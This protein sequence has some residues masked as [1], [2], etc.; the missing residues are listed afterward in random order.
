MPLDSAPECV[1]IIVTKWMDGMDVYR[2]GINENVAIKHISTCNYEDLQ[3]EPTR[4]LEYIQA[5]VPLLREDSSSPYFTLMATKPPVDNT[6][7]V[8]WEDVPVLLH[9]RDLIQHYVQVYDED[10]SFSIDSLL[11]QAWVRS[12]SRKGE[13]V[14]G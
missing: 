7:A 13:S 2:Y 1:E 3:E 4:L 8:S 12:G 6:R 10:E 11:T 9:A 14:Q 5:H